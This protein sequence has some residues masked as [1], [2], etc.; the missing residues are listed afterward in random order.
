MRGVSFVIVGLGDS[1]YSRSGAPSLIFAVFTDTG[2]FNWAARKLGKRL[3]QLG[4][5]ETVET[6]EAD[7]Q[8]EEG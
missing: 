8:G 7:E 3:K 4:A 2:R 6:C 1:S 5:E